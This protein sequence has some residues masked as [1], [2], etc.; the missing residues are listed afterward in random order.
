MHDSLGNLRSFAASRWKRPG[1]ESD[2]TTLSLYTE[3][4]PLERIS[5]GENA[6]L[7]VDAHGQRRS[8]RRSPL[9][10]RHHRR[11][12]GREATALGRSAPSH[13]GFRPTSRGGTFRGL[14]IKNGGD[15]I[16]RGLLVPSGVR[17]D[18]ARSG[19][20]GQ[21]L[22]LHPPVGDNIGIVVAAD[23]SISAGRAKRPLLLEL[24]SPLAVRLGRPTPRDPD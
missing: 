10:G 17:V 11:R 22:A 7:F 2:T 14:R 4:E 20:D 12:L 18:S 15:A 21:P 13:R 6:R 5:T 3:S 8:R 9:P 23:K 19:V 24:I 1:R 16:V